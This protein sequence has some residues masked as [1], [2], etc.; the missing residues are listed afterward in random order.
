MTKLGLPCSCNSFSTSTW[1]LL[2]SGALLRA[3]TGTR[4]N[5]V[6]ASQDTLVAGRFHTS[7]VAVSGKIRHI[8]QA[9]GWRHGRVESKNVYCAGYTPCYRQRVTCI[10]GCRKLP[11]S[12]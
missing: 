12:A 6:L 3:G 8:M 7:S 1:G 4:F 11:D 5:V 10:K 9:N 2:L